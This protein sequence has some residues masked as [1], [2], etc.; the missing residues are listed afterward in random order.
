M[1]MCVSVCG[2][3]AAAITLFQVS[4]ACTCKHKICTL[5]VPCLGC[6][7]DTFLHMH[8]CAQLIRVTCSNQPHHASVLNTA[9]LLQASHVM[10]V[11]TGVTCTSP[12]VLNLCALTKTDL[13]L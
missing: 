12:H 2:C 10:P 13:K 8:T 1:L 9:C 7:P 11:S 6:A 5:H 4:P 3:S